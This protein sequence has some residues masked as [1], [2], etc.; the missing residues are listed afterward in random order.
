LI[1]ALGL[2]KKENQITK[3]RGKK[4]SIRTYRA[5]A[6]IAAGETTATAYTSNVKGRILKVGINYPTNTCTVDIDS[7]DEAHS[8]KILDLAAGNT[9]KTVY[10]RVALHDNTG[11]AIDL[12]DAQ[13]GNTAMYGY[14]VV[15]G[16]LKLSLASGTAT[17]SVTIQVD[18]EE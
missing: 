17:E 18:V 10:P 5:T 1:F 14:F 15:N 13:G 16:R 4:M 3:L 6:T 12:S 2:A 9:D 8:Q 11:T 7:Q